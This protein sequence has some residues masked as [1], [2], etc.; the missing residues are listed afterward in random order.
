MVT[1]EKKVFMLADLSADPLAENDLEYFR[2]QHSDLLQV[3][4]CRISLCPAFYVIIQSG[5]HRSL[6]Q[7]FANTS[8]Q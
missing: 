8:N 3:K 4:L 5:A 6:K 2:G 1:S 7:V